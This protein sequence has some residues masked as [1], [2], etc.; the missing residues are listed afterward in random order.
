[1]PLRQWQEVQEVPRAIEKSLAVREREPSGSRFLSWVRGIINRSTA[2]YTPSMSIVSA[3]RRPCPILLS[4]I[5]ALTAPAHTAETARHPVD[6][7]ARYGV[8]VTTPAGT[9]L[10][11][12]YVSSDWNK[13]Q[14]QVTRALIIFH[15][16]KRNAAAYFRSAQ[17]AVDE[18]GKA[19]RGTIVIAPQFLIDEDAAALHLASPILRWRH[20]EW[21]SGSDATGPVPISSFDAVDAILAQL[22]DRSRFANLQQVVLAGH[23]GGGQILQ[24]YA[25]VGRGED[26]LIKVGVRVRYVVANPSSYVY[27]SDERPLSANSFTHYA[28]ACRSFNR[29][30]YGTVEPPSYVGRS[31]F[32]NMEES[33]ARRDV[34]YLLGTAD[35]D[36]HH[37]DLDI[38]CEA[39]AEGPNRFARG[40][41]YF[42]YMKGRHLD[43]LSQRLWLVHGVAHDERGMFHSPCGMEAL[44]DIPGCASAKR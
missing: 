36:P 41:A 12:I 8:R 18:A 28:G 24:R 31:S 13:P 43:A 19:G 37:S 23:S 35:T 25:V 6:E 22:A 3:L 11:P 39:E 29:W 2:G 20:P 4:V 21:E 42:A 26:A 15:G 34:I 44:F 40:T 14:P 9:G 5:I 30:K 17:E 33:Y 27:F 38:S 32:S 7:I 1:M 16:V 10:L